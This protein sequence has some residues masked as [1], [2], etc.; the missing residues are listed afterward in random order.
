[1]KN[2]KKSLKSFSLNKHA[3]TKLQMEKI[4]GGDESNA[5]LVIPGC[6]THPK[7]C[8]DNLT[9]DRYCTSITTATC[10]P[11]GPTMECTV[12]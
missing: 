5:T 11:T 7:L 3:I 4:E 6:H 10:N 8:I 12:A 2:E 1:M 9:K